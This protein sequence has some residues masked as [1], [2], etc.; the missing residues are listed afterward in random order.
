M[1]SYRADQASLQFNLPDGSLTAIYPSSARPGVTV[2]RLKAG[3]ALTVTSHW[4][5]KYI[6]HMRINQGYLLITVGTSTRI[7]GPEDGTIDILPFQIH[8][9]SQGTIPAA[10]P[11]LAQ[12]NGLK[13]GWEEEDVVFEE[14]N[15]PV[16]GQ[17]EVFFRNLFGFVK[18]HF[19][20]PING[21]L[22]LTAVLGLL[23]HA[24]EL[25]NSSRALDNY[26]LFMPVSMGRARSGRPSALGRATTYSIY[27][28][29]QLVSW[30]C[31]YSWWR[32]EYTP[33]ELHAVC[34]GM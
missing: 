33:V 31:G 21:K 29:A 2:G 13:P 24:M 12:R 11:Y 17:K 27:R 15:T 6:E 16:D 26:M 3:G 18:D 8:S 23:L 14:W 20:G 9:I 32:E 7:Y 19:E 30:V 25:L 10:K 34:K 4:H 28:V 5:E 22:R 1:Y